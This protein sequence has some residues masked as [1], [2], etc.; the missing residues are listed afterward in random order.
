[1]KKHRIRLR[2]LKTKGDKTRLEIRNINEEIKEMKEQLSEVLEGNQSF[3]GLKME[4]EEIKRK[5]QKNK[6]NEKL[7]EKLTQSKQNYNKRRI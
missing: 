6:G 4:L 1:M 5:E 2:K 7:T 3:M